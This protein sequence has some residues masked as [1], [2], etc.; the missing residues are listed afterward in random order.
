MGYTQ[1]SALSD[2]GLILPP[3]L[4]RTLR[5]ITHIIILILHKVNSVVLLLIQ[6]INASIQVSDICVLPA[7]C[8]LIN[9]DVFCM[10]S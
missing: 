10:C 1:Q 9:P 4:F 7:G 8:R 6:F 3:S 5:G 2:L